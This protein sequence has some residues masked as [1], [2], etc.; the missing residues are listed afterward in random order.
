MVNNTTYKITSLLFPPVDKW[1]KNVYSQGKQIGT[2]SDQLPTTSLLGGQFTHLP[3]YN[4]L[5]TPL[6]V[7]VFT[8]A[9]CTPKIK[10]YHLLKRHLY[11]QSTPPINKKKNGKM[12]R[13]T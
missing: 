8:P 2:T 6:F 12:E 11:P 1:I 10:E 7:Q 5:V 9:L 3:V 4:S 13:N